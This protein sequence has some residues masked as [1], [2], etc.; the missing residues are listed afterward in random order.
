MWLGG[1]P[2]HRLLETRNVVLA[3]TRAIVAAAAATAAP[4]RLTAVLALAPLS[5][6]GRGVLGGRRIA[7]PRD[8]LSNQL[9]DR[10]DG[11]LVDRRHD[12][13]RGARASGAAG[14]A[15]AVYVVVGMM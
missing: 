1:R 5:R 15:D 8:R 3:L 10:A 12:G 9:L 14:A 7:G 13:D 11:L 4:T 6:L 2:R